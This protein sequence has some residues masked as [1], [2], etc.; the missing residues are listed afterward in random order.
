LLK[1]LVPE[2]GILTKRYPRKDEWEDIRYG[3]RVAREIAGLDLGQTVVVKNRAVIAIE[4]MEGTDKCI[5][6][7]GE[8][9]KG[10]VIVKMAKP[11]QD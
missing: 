4:A 3:W 5:R 9:V 7:A 1:H 11:E 8:L 2:E 6:R 10:C